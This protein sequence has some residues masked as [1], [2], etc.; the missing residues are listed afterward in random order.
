MRF[1]TFQPRLFQMCALASV[2]LCLAPGSRNAFGANTDDDPPV[3]TR[4]VILDPRVVSDDFGKRIAKSHL[5]MQVTVANNNKEMDLIILHAA[6]DLT[7]ALS[8][9][10]IATF[11]QNVK[12]VNDRLSLQGGARYS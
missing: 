9:Q 8:Q 5:A 3:E 10:R 12:E 6:F 7:K 11:Q 2:F 4:R 1:L